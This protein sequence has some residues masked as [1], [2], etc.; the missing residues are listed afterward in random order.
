MRPPSSSPITTYGFASEKFGW[1]PWFLGG[2]EYKK[3]LDED[4][5]RV[6]GILDSLGLIKKS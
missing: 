1:T 5:K 3:F 4:I 2:D 6:G